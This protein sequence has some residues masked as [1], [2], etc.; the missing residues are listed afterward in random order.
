MAVTGRPCHRRHLIESTHSDSRACSRE[1]N[2]AAAC[3]LHTTLLNTATRRVRVYPPRTC[4]ALGCTDSCKSRKRL[5]GVVHTLVTQRC[6]MAR[7][8]IIVP[9]FL[10][11]HLHEAI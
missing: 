10:S 4:G 9:H 3:L 5:S 2:C 11:R 1:G 8:E 7:R 6:R